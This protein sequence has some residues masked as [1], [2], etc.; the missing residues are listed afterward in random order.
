MSENKNTLW[1]LFQER[2]LSRRS[3]VKSCVALTA[4]L[5]LPP[6]MFNNVVKAAETK[7]APVVIWL[8]GQEC[9]GCTES[10][11]RSGAPY[12]SDVVLNI[13]DLE[14]QDTI[15]AGQGQLLEEHLDKVMEENKGKYVLVVEGADALGNDGTYCMVGGIPFTEKL[16]QCA[17]NAAFV[18]TYGSCASWGGI[19]AA[20][21]NPSNSVMVSE[22]VSGVPVVRVPGCPPIPE[23]MTGVIMSY[24]LFGQL[25]PVDSQGRPKQFYGNRIHDTCY[26]RAFFDSG[27]FV[28][29]FDDD[30][31][32]AGWCLYKVGCRGPETY[33]SCGNLR[34]WNGLSYPIQSGHGCIGCSEEGFWDNGDFYTRMPNIYTPNSI[35]DADTVGAVAAGVAGVGVVAHG[36]MSILN[37][38]REERIKLAEEQ[39]KEHKEEND[40]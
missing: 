34:W 30:G 26:R 20:S 38:R 5:G 12:A 24:A 14:Y 3:F 16:K 22:T 19:Q 17:K 32:K 35:V 15:D 27:L 25:P 10:F 2:K 4:I 36:A 11:I 39:E 28:E 8:H 31:A 18:I 21:P 9:T 7:E 37:H 13:I 6:T 40:K 23:V 29:E 1:S 33:N